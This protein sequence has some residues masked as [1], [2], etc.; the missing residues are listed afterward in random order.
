MAIT[1]ATDLRA[2]NFKTVIVVVEIDGEEF[3]FEGVLTPDRDD[4]FAQVGYEVV[5]KECATVIRFTDED[6]RWV[7]AGRAIRLNDIKTEQQ[8]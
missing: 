1:V 7:A 8:A 4:T 6:V 2:L 3:I 5:D